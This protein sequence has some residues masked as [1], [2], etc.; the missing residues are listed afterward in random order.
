[1]GGDYGGYDG[2]CPPW[3]DSIMHHFHFTVFALDVQ[4]LDLKGAF[5]G[6]GVLAAMKG[7]VLDQ[8]SHMGTL[9]VVI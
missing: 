7:H 6:A 2:P 3:N 1:M 4:L 8:E 9:S 5:T